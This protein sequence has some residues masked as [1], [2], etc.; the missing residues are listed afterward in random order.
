MRANA[1]RKFQRGSAAVLAEHRLAAGFGRTQNRQHSISFRA[2]TLNDGNAQSRSQTGASVATVFPKGI[3]FYSDR[4]NLG[5]RTCRWPLPR[6][7]LARP[8]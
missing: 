6:T 4:V 8:A 2:G 3:G 7:F 1:F 5:G